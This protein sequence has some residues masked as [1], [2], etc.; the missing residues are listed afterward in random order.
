M[1]QQTLS[2]TCLMI[3]EH[4]SIQVVFKTILLD[5]TFVWNAISAK[6]TTLIN[7]LNVW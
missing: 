6:N 4:L 3:D 2:L 7:P 1:G 5:G